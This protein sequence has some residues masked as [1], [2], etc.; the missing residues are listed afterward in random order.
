MD[1]NSGGLSFE[2]RQ[3]QTAAEIAR[4]KVMAAYK[5]MPV[6]TQV[7]QEDFK[8][9][10]SA[11]QGYYQKYYSEY[12]ANA[13]KQY[14]ETEELKRK[15]AAE[16]LRREEILTGAKNTSTAD[17]KVI[18]DNSLKSRI[19]KLADEEEQH[20]KR[21]KKWTPIVA[22]LTV[23]AI[24]VFLQYNRMIF[25]PIMAYVSPGNASET[26]IT[27][28]DPTVAVAVKAEPTLLIPKLNIDVPINM[29]I[30][31]SSAAVMEAMNHG[32]ARFAIPGASA[33][34]GQ[35]GNFVISGHSAGDIY[36]NNQYK[37]IFSG[38]E[39]LSGGDL[40]YVDY[41]GQRYTYSVTK[42]DT[43]EPT[44]VAAL[45][46]ETDKPILTLITCWPLGTSRYRLLVV[47]EQINPSV[48]SS[49]Q[50]QTEKP[51]AQTSTEAI[52]PQNEPTFFESIWNWL[53]GN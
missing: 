16:D 44:N 42:L 51:V 47:A 32:V 22:G 29:S 15:R 19:R 39:R 4:R 18:E 12:Y 37:F 48:N 6:Q 24:L 20:K 14:I 49:T 38:L 43:V 28:V 13:A 27:E 2:E 10:H 25:A 41:E 1:S 45:V 35:I 46:Y 53:T 9:Y 8:K 40:I 21:M 36:S 5:S 26:S 11:W 3:R 30:D 31:N 23:V 7:T 33:V 50:P 52:L 34:P 17:N